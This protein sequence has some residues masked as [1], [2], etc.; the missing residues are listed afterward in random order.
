MPEGEYEEPQD[1]LRG[2]FSVCPVKRVFFS[3]GN[4]QFQASTNTRRFAEC[5]Y[6]F[7]GADNMKLSPSC[8]VFGRD[9]SGYDHGAVNYQL[10]NGNKDTKEQSLAP[11]IRQFHLRLVRP[12][13]PSR[14][15]YNRIA[16]GGNQENLWRTPVVAEWAFALFTRSTASGLLLPRRTSTDRGFG[17]AARQLERLYLSLQFPEIVRDLA[18]RSTR[19]ACRTGYN[20]LSLPA[21]CF[22][23]WQA[24]GPSTASIGIQE[25]TTPPM[26]PT[27]ITST[28]PKSLLH[29][30]VTNGHRGDGLVVCLVREAAE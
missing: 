27:P 4:L 19:S 30:D 22:C 11:R 28:S 21:R 18:F 8:G 12:V 13:W 29:V 16:N 2:L 10:W 17:F 26:P 7:V 14:L 3:K 15:G 24:P 25:A 1:A 20:A 5:Q 23:L 9:T 6:E